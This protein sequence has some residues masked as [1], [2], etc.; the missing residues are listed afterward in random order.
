MR[1]RRVSH[2]LEIP[3]AMWGEVLSFEILPLASLDFLAP[4]GNF[5]DYTSGWL[6]HNGGFEIALP[7][8]TINARGFS[9]R[10]QR[11]AYSG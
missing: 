10:V 3:K 2:K 5:E 6:V 8:L 11:L 7:N 9:I 1:T 4:Y